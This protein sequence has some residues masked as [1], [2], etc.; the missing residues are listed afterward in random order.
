MGIHELPPEDDARPRNRGGCP[1]YSRC[2]QS[3]ER[4]LQAQPPLFHLEGAGH[5]VSC[6]LYDHD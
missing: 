3:M 4:C 6:Y 2:H 5:E 1:F